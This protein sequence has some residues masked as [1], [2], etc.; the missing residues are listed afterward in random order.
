MEL[1]CL[2][3]LKDTLEMILWTLI[4]SHYNLKQCLVSNLQTSYRAAFRLKSRLE[5]RKL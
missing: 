1:I 2:K 3:L 5:K 4:P